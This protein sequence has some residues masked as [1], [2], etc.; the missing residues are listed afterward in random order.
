VCL[1]AIFFRVVED[2]PL[3]VGANREEFYAR[4]GEPPRIIDGPVPALAGID[5]VAGGT[6]FGVN[7]RGL[8]AAVTNRPKSEIPP[9]PPSRGLL[10]RELLGCPDTHAAVAL[11]VRELGTNRYAGCNLL[12]ADQNNA[13]VIHGGDWLRVR[14][15][16][17]GLHVLTASDVNDA[18][19][20]RLGHA[21]WWLAQRRYASSEECVAALKELC[22]QTGNGDPPICLRGPDRGTVSSSIVVLRPN[23]SDSR[24]LHSQ[25]PPDRVA[26]DDYADRLAAMAQPAGDR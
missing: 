18:G 2:A 23:I 6:W 3:I 9:Q 11:A 8:L 16:P 26:Y 13:V 20:R 4:G 22:A 25:G 19:D 5:P 21:L 1:L 15:L 10:V 17:P 12:L 24:Y 14:P 7:A